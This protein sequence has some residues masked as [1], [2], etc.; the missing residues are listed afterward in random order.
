MKQT[1]E[2]I[3]DRFLKLGIDVPEEDIESRLDELITKFK[4]PSNEA[5]RSVTNYFLKKYSIPKNEFYA[6]QAEPQ[7]TKITDILENGQ[8]ANMKVKVIQL[9]ENT[10]ESI[11]QVG[12]LGDETGII[13]FTKWQNTEL[14]DL[15]QGESYLLRNIVIDEYNGKFQVKLNRT[16]SVE[17]LAEAVDVAG[18]DF[19]PAARESELMNIADLKE[20]NQWAT[21][22]GKIV[23][24]W[25]NS[26]EAIEQAGL[27]GDETGV[28][29]FTNWASSELPDME[30][31]KSYLLKN[32]VVNEWNGRFQVK[33]N[34][35]SSIEEL[36]EDIEVGTSTFTYFGALVDIQTG[37]GLIKRCPE[38]KRALVKGACAEHGKVKGEY[39]L[40]I[41]AVMDSGT[42][43]QDA[44]I[45]RE[46]TEELAGI[47]LDSAIA[48]AADALDPGVV[49]D[50]LK[51]ELVGRY[52]TVTGHKLD[53]YI[54]VE[55]I[56]PRVSLDGELLEEMLVDL[57]VE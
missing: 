56:A 37:S 14:P 5:Q 9:W 40:R 22:R 34:R 43:T 57:G 27:I 48:M 10:H 46:L 25:E 41:K 51:H 6:R 31:G 4:V 54:L 15:E 32:I 26:H 19:T 20:D 36:D 21:I 18:G 33:L 44:L 42:S 8:W 16:S 29:K 55:S 47:S 52:Y 53:R 45:N 28:I 38:C 23:Q 12:L 13:K 11:S 24:L 7:L 2:S 17:K 1:A 49:L 50:R 35:A 39:D 3:K 30:E